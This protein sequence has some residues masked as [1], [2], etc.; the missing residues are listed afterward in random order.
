MKYGAP[1]LTDVMRGK[2]GGVVFTKARSG[3]TVR[4]R[5]KPGNPRTT[6]QIDVRA[7]LTAA[8]REWGT[9]SSSDVDAWNFAA[10]ALTFPNGLGG[11]FVPTG[12]MRYMQL[13]AKFF[14]INGITSPPTTPPT[15][16]FTG[17]TITIAGAGGSGVV[18]FDPS[19]ANTSG[20]TTELFIQRLLGVNRRLQPNA[21]RHAQFHVF[22][23]GS[24]VVSISLP[25]GTYALG[26]KFCLIA[27]GEQTGLFALGT[28][29]VT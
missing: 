1:L 18:T 3:P 11:S 5:I 29:Q 24:D 25:A 15:T 20:V 17:D 23:G 2:L 16:P 22:T 27:T 13:T 21:Y 7:N 26:Y 6:A 12:N 8:S 4:V 9:L 28:F 19:A 10:S 14:Q